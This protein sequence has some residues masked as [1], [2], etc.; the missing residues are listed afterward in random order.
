[1]KEFAAHTASVNCLALGHKSGRVLVTGGD[2]KK[3]NLWAVGK[4]NCIMSLSGHSTPVE[5]VRF[6]PS[7]ELVCAGSLSGA[8]KIWNLEAA[9]IVRTLNGHKAN[10]RCIDFHPYGDF[11]ASGSLDTNIKL[12][13]IR[14]KGCIYTYHG[15][16]MTVNS[17]KFSPDGQWI[18]SAGEDT[19][20]KLWDLRA[21]KLL[22]EFSGHTASVSSVEFHPDEL[23]LASG[24]NDRKVHFWDLESLNLVSS[25]EADCAAIRCIYF[26]PEGKRLFAGSQGVLKVYGWEPGRTYDTLIMGWG[27]VHDIATAQK[28]LIGASFH[29]TNVSLYVVDLKRVHPVAGE[30]M[31]STIVCNNPKT[32]SHSHLRKSFNREKNCSTTGGNSANS[33]FKMQL[34]DSD[35]V[36]TDPEDDTSSAADI[37]DEDYVSIFQPRSRDLRRTPPPQPEPFLAPP[38]D[39]II[40]EMPPVPIKVKEMTPRESGPGRPGREGIGAPVK[41]PRGPDHISRRDSLPAGAPDDRGSKPNINS[42]NSYSIKEIPSRLRRGD[43]GIERPSVVHTNPKTL[44][45]VPISK[46]RVDF[47]PFQTE[48]PSGLNIEEFLPRKMAGLSVGS[49]LPSDVGLS[50]AEVIS[51]LCRSHKSMLTILTGRLR[52]HQI[53][54]SIWS[55]KDP[56]HCVKHEG[57]LMFLSLMFTCLQHAIDSAV[58]MRD[59]SIVVDLLSILNLR[60]SMWNLDLCVALLPSLQELLES[61]F[62]LHMTTGCNALKVILKNFASVIKTNISVPVHTVGVDIS[63]EERYGKCMECYNQ[64][65]SIRAFILKRQTLQGKLGHLFRE[66]H[67]LMQSLD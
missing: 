65:L 27:N 1:M 45:S 59:P 58:A 29:M 37:R 49:L 63:R 21:G 12:W 28:Q 11:L 17:L 24:G 15:H 6:G 32:F 4:P 48:Q 20:V 56:K 46:E 51:T 14:R 41:P 7:E 36:T 33:N 23:L 30:A 2:D 62:E 31:I 5:C 52:Q 34:E 53:V 10:I 26:D 64:L 67:L 57:E 55:S 18:A 43:T 60:P 8:M 42:L 16:T 44:S 13:D 35:T 54:H 66:L 9:K 39:D 47:I 50:E 25:T 3:V 19:T 61:K 22:K 38:E 40:G